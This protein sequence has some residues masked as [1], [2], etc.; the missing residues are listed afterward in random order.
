MKPHFLCW[1]LVSNVE[2]KTKKRG[3]LKQRS[4][5]ILGKSLHKPVREAEKDC[6]LE[7]H[8]HQLTSSFKF[9]VS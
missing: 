7:R 9:I 2:K 6:T 5:A 8:Q 3:Q 1:F 4:A